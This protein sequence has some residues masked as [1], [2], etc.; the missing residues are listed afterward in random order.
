MG[1]TTTTPHKAVAKKSARVPNLVGL[2]IKDVVRATV[3]GDEDQQVYFV[4]ELSDGGELW[5]EQDDEGNGP[6]TFFYSNGKAPE[7]HANEIV[8][9]ARRAEH[10]RRSAA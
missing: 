3:N 10:Q 2:T 7:V 6:G 4:I 9:A 5:M 1:T 8:D